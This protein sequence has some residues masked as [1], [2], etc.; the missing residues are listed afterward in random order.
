[1][2]TFK[3]WNKK[4]IEDWKTTCS[5]DYKSFVRAFKNYLKRTFPNYELTGFRPNHYDT[6]GFISNGKT[7]IYISQSMDRDQGHINF[8]DTGAHRGILFRKVKD[9]HDYHG[10]GNHF[11]SIYELEDE[12]KT[13][14]N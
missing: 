7:T 9:T 14:L 1:M 3:K 6:S 12:L 5:S 8:E 11:C 4:P 13:I 2:K 10:E